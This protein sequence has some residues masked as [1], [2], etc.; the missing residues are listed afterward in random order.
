M[1]QEQIRMKVLKKE[2]QIVKIY[3]DKHIRSYFQKK[4]DNSIFQN[5]LDVLLPAYL[6]KN[7]YLIFAS[8]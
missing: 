3:M 4:D 5:L 2:N 8:V 7:Y 6:F 1:G